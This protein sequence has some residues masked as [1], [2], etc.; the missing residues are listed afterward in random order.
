[1]QPDSLLGIG[2]AVLGIG[3]PA[4]VALIKL[5]PQREPKQSPWKIIDCPVREHEAR[6]S[7]I[8]KDVAVL[9]ENTASVR[10][11]LLRI[12]SKLDAFNGHHDQQR[13]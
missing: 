11:T 5:L 12:E 7:E 4:T 8:E 9:Q 2:L 6:M 13:P 10:A 1:M 3:A